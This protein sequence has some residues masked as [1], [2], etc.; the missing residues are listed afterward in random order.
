MNDD[1]LLLNI[2]SLSALDLWRGCKVYSKF[3]HPLF[4][5]CIS[6]SA[7]LYQ[8]AVQLY[9]LYIHKNSSSSSEL[10]MFEWL[11]FFCVLTWHFISRSISGWVLELV[12][13]ISL[14]EYSPNNGN[15]SIYCSLHARKPFKSTTA[16]SR[17]QCHSHIWQLR[18]PCVCVCVRAQY[19]WVAI[20]LDEAFR[21][22]L[23]A[24]WTIGQYVRMHE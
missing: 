24:T 16:P 21:G 23:W 17:H 10:L 12:Y 3:I 8:N 9:P 7:P 11:I 20:R 4:G 18:L 6:Y 5:V 14:R 13:W 1:I 22:R 15:P 2:S 19:F